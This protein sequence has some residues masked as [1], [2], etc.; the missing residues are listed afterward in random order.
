[1]G[2]RLQPREQGKKGKGKRFVKIQGEAQSGYW[3]PLVE[4]GKKENRKP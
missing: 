2:G 1:M 3:T 4:G